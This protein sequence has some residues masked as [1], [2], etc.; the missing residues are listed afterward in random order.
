MVSVDEAGDGG[1]AV[2]IND[3]HAASVWRT[4][5][6]GDK[7]SVASD[8]RT[9]LNHVTIAHDDADIGDREVLR[10]EM[11]GASHAHKEN[12]REK[13]K[14]SLHCR[15]PQFRVSVIDAPDG[16]T[17][18]DMGRF[19]RREGFEFWRLGAGS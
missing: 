18:A 1:H 12:E 4:R 9:I 14:E 11:R 16:D 17:Y 15:K 10:R 19:V 13:S 2:R 3:L 5:G 7:L 8:D 6:N